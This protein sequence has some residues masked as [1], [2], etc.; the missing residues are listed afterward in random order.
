[1]NKR[2]LL[3][4]SSFLCFQLFFI[5]LIYADSALY[6]EGQVLVKYKNGLSDRSR[7]MIARQV[8]TV[9]GERF[10]DF[11]IELIELPYYMSVEDAVKKYRFYPKVEAAGPNYY[12]RASLS[13]NDTSFS[14]QW[15][16]NNTG[17]TVNLT[18]GTSDA[19]IDAPEAWDASTGSSSVV[20]ALLD[21]GMDLDNED[22]SGNL[23]VNGGETAGNGIDDDGNGRVDDVNGWDFVNSDNDPEDDDVSTSHGTFMSGIIG[24]VGNN[25]RVYAGLTGQ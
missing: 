9:R 3:F 2:P 19:D 5:T 15:A 10:E 22:L 1:M 18:T 24:A 17:Q 14:N 12:I 4:L 11:G 20:I 6:K 13:P 23:W 7:E 25:A 21:T 8:N 16:L